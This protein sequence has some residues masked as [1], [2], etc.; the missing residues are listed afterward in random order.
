M[1]SSGP[2]AD[3]ATLLR[4]TDGPYADWKAQLGRRD[5]PYAEEG[6]GVRFVRV[7]MRTASPSL[8]LMPVRMRTGGPKATLLAWKKKRPRQVAGPSLNSE[9]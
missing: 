5:C 3:F 2:Y 4:N 6:R 9:A 8:A 1:V 7:H